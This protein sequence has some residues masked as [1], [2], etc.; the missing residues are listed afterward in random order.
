MQVS[1]FFTIDEIK[2][3][4]EL[5]AKFQQL[6]GG[7]KLLLFEN[8]NIY[9]RWMEIQLTKHPERWVNLVRIKLNN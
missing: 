4:K 9:D 6:K 8:T 5:G 7:Q 1:G 3:A 2:T